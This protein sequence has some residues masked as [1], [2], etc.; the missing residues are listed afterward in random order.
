M[1]SAQAKRLNGERAT[2]LGPSRG[3]QQRVEQL[4]ERF[5]DAAATYPTLEALALLPA[6]RS[7]AR[8]ADKLLRSRT[9]MNALVPTVA[10][11]APL[12]L[13]PRGRQKNPLWQ[14]ITTRR[15]P[16]L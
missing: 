6:A 2:A 16:M 8:T 14:T 13:W 7:V 3:L 10:G 11:L 9:P 4:R 5:S 15:F 12:L 1:T